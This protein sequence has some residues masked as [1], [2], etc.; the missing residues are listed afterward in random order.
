MLQARASGGRHHDGPRLCE[1]TTLTGVIVLLPPSESKATRARGARLDL[2]GLS[3]PELTTAREHVASALAAASADPDAARILGVSANL[4]DEIARNTRLDTAP[5]L[6]AA[7]LYT[8]VLYDALDLGRLAG[9]D[10][11][12]ATRRIVIS[13]ALYGA[14]RL[15]DR[16][17]PYRLSMGVNLPPLGPL[18]AHWR[19]ALDTPMAS[20]IGAGLVVDCRSSTYAAA[21]APSGDLAR[22]WVHI[23]V[24][25][26]THMA[27]HTRGLVTRT[28]VTDPRDPR[29]PE[30]LAEQLAETYDVRLHEPAA[31]SKSWILDVRAREAM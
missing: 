16:L 22:R 12:R 31:A 4:G 6:P 9:A 15:G 14:V 10:K 27:K 30:A 17:A 13:S 28:L 21:W 18:A 25:G 19:S 29:R 3:F 26:A 1:A 5:T 2:G 24:P 20:A 23:R 8:G 7:Q 11:A